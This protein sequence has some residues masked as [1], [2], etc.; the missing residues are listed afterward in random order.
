MHTS[1]TL[2]YFLASPDRTIY[3]NAQ[4]IL[5]RLQN[6]PHERYENVTRAQDPY[7]SADSAKMRQCTVCG[8]IKPHGM[9]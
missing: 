1:K 9:R 4:S 8:I 7:M 3:R 2:A 6:C 5:K